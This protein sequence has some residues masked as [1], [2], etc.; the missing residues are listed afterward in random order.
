MKGRLPNQVEPR[1]RRFQFSLRAVL[2][3]VAMLCVILT[4]VVAKARSTNAKWRV[5]AEIEAG[6][7]N[8][9]YLR[10]EVDDAGD[11]I[12]RSRYVPKTGNPVWFDDVV[13]ICLSSMRNADDMCAKIRV[14]PRLETLVIYSDQLSKKSLADLKC[15]T[16]LHELLVQGSNMAGDEVSHILEIPSLRRL[17]LLGEDVT[18]DGLKWLSEARQL[19]QLGVGGPKLTDHCLVYF[20]GLVDL[21]ELDFITPQCATPVKLKITDEGLKKLQQHLPNTIIRRDGRKRDED[22]DYVPRE[23]ARR[24]YELGCMLLRGP[25]PALDRAMSAFNEA[26]RLDRCYGRAIESRAMLLIYQGKL[27]EGIA[28]YSRVIELEPRNDRALGG[29]ARAYCRLGKTK[30]AMRDVKEALRLDG[31]QGYQHTFDLALVHCSMGRYGRAI[32]ELLEIFES[33]E[34]A[35]AYLAGLHVTWIR[36]TCEDRRFRDAVEAMKYVNRVV[37]ESGD[38]DGFSTEA[39][40]VVA[41][42]YAEN[43]DFDKAVKFQRMALERRPD[44]WPGRSQSELRLKLYRS[45]QPYRMRHPLDFFVH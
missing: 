21:E 38:V 41:A 6:H 25:D 17:T 8:K 11:V 39:C 40:E 33:G 32:A 1:R 18:D 29:R 2:L 44:G 22:E 12:D 28:D 13:M 42:A 34:P 23:E 20:E 16:R 43:R 15:H 36:A 37:A 35:W 27:E 24:Q 5:I 45:R 7:G 30:E 4:I 14:F 19:R 9:V 3:F 10:S 31:G 26:I